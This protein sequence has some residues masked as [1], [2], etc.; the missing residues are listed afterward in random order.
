MAHPNHRLI[1]ALRIAAQRLRNG[2]YY[3][4]GH[5]G[6]CNCGNL[7]QVITNLTKEEILTYAHS[8]TGEWS[9]IADAYCMLTGTPA[10]LMISKLEALGLT[11]TD[12]HNLEYLEDKEVLNN[13]PGG[14]RWLKRNLREDVISYF[15]S[16]ADLLS[17]KLQ[18]K[19]IDDVESLLK[20][21]N[22]D[23]PVGELV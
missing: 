3:A 2:A 21:I 4:W 13:L 11:A 17:V 8:G 22:S 18:R 23:L 7:L 15:E 1:E 19:P 10:Y 9:E 14:F 12:I 5:H 16:L 20:K 6:G